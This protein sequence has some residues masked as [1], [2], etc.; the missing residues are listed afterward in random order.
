MNSP[1]NPDGRTDPPTLPDLETFNGLE[2][3]T[4]RG[5]LGAGCASPRWAAAVADGR[6]YATVADLLTASDDAFAALGPDDVDAALAGHPRIGE[7][8]TGTGQ[9]VRFSRREQSAVADSDAAVQEQIR[10]GNLA[11]EERF[12]RVFLIRAAGR[13]PEEIL[14]ELSRRLGHDDEAEAAEVVEQLRQIT[15]LR[16]QEL[17]TP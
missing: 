3:D 10:E 4:A 16:L 5:V 11:Y 6:P 13:S 14:A 15:H 8:A 7:C 12:D 17:I 1:S 9:D 2:A